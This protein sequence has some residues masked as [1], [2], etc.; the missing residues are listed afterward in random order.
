MSVSVIV[1][2]RNAAAFVAEAVASVLAQGR[3]VEELII[4][5]DGSTDQ[6]VAIVRG[7]ADMRIRVVA[8]DGAGVS[9]AR[10]AGA[11]AAKG[12]WLMFL[13]A[14]D[15]LHSGAIPALLHASLRESQAVAIYGD[16]SR[17]D[18]NGRRIGMR[19]LLRA[20]AKPTGRV[21]TRMAAGNFIVNG[22][23]MIIRATSFAATGGFDETMRYCEDW[24]CWCRLA[25]LGEFLFI[26]DLLL[27]YRVHG[28]NTMSA[29]AR[30]PQDFLPAADRVFRDQAIVGSLSRDLVSS[31]RKA[32]E[33]HLITYAA[34]QA[35]RFRQYRKTLAYIAMAGR[36][37]LPAMP[38]VVFRVGMAVF[39]I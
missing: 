22:G 20:R 12:D 25:A 16:Y 36:R 29:A 11:R 7:F 32:A 26:P 31:L 2:A 23:L 15:R 34:T 5:D 24:H 38:R 30:T 21:L 18:R 9:A 37:S 3:D 27:D 19:H 8:N 4:V 1:P 39:G 13:D 14:D 33:V 10:N 28:D 17:I 35:I 6:T